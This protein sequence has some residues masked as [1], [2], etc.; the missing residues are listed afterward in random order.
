MSKPFSNGNR[1]VALSEFSKPDDGTVELG[2]EEVN[3]NLNEEMQ[4]AKQSVA[5]KKV[6]PKLTAFLLLNAMIGAGILNVPYT[7]KQSGV[8]LGLF[9]FLFFAFLTWFSL[10]VL[11]YTGI[12][13][14][15]FDYGELAFKAC[16][17]KGSICVD[18][19][20]V[21]EGVGGCLGYLVII[22]NNMSSVV[23]VRSVCC[24]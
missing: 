24:H 19:W 4:N 1:G 15:T 16:A 13:T 7:F 9:I 5:R 11:I 18:F 8:G 2:P 6:G 21:L 22:G 14:K 3:V 23:Q 20:T 17:K 10:I 12:R